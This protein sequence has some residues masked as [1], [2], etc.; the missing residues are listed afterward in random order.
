L[1][2]AREIAMGSP[3]LKEKVR[4]L[5]YQNQR[6]VPSKIAEL[7]RPLGTRTELSQA[8]DE[9]LREEPNMMMAMQLKALKVSIDLDL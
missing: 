7:A 8:V 6:E 5:V 2:F 4:K 9:L 1:S 3:D